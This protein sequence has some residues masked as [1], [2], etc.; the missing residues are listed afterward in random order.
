MS[1]AA[2]LCNRLILTR[3]R[4]P[5]DAILRKNQAG[6]RTGRS[7]IQQIHILRRI[8]DGAFTQNILLLITF[9]DFK[10][11][12]NSNDRDI[13]F[14]ILQCYG[15]PDKIDSAI[16]V[17]YDQSTSH[18][19]IQGQLSE[20]FAITTGVLQGDLLALFIFIIFHLHLTQNKSFYRK[21]QPFHCLSR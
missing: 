2:K 9:V 14:A 15:I 21:F 12:F 10:K 16:R 1:L 4:S 11:A 20:P 8:M 17:L 5:I 7:C 3:I 18:V 13:M 19:Y 6:F